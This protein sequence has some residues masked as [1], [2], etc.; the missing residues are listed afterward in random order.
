MSQWVIYVDMNTATM[1]SQ[2]CSIW[3]QFLSLFPEYI[4]SWL[5]LKQMEGSSPWR[6]FSWVQPTQTKSPPPPPLA[7]IVF[8]LINNVH[9]WEILIFVF[10]SSREHNKGPSKCYTSDFTKHGTHNKTKF[11]Q[12]EIPGNTSY[13][14]LTSWIF[15][16]E[17]TIKDSSK[18]KLM[19]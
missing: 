16:S 19:V 4:K 17:L 2:K 14:R 9:G 7:C 11:T 12:Q 10:V 6:A 3:M 15:I 8:F 5:T 18:F 13:Y 1:T